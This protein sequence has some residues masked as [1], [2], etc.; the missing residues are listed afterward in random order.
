MYTDSDGNMATWLK[1][2]FVAVAV[3][4][5]AVIVI[6]VFGIAVV[7]TATLAYAVG[8]N[9]GKVNDSKEYVNNND[10][11]AMD[12]VKFNTIQKI[13]NTTGLNREDKLAYIRRYLIENP[14][15]ADYWSE[16]QMLREFEYHD[17]VYN[18][19]YNWLGISNDESPSSNTIYVDFEKP[20]TI[21]TYVFRFFGNMIP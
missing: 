21:R 4:A 9:I 10:V 15:Y 19:S 17:R 3:V 18:I 7:A 14:E 6:A 11:A 5:V 12:S 8:S 1:L 16:A 2:A 13:G 20:Q